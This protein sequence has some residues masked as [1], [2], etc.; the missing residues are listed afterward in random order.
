MVVGVS[1]IARDVTERK[2]IERQKDI[3]LGIAA[4]ELRTPVAGIK[5]YAQLAARRLQRDGE[6][7]AVEPLVQL[8][9]Q[10]DRLMR[11]I[12]DL[13]NV[14]RIESD[15]LLL[16][17]APVVLDDLITDVAAEFQR[18][19]D[20]H[21]IELV[22]DAPV[23]ITA[24]RDRIEQ[25]VMNLLTNAVKFSPDADVVRIRTSNDAETVVVSVEDF[26]VGIPKETQPHI[27]ER[28]YRIGGQNNLGSPGLG[29]GLFISSEYVKRHGGRIWV[30]SV[31]GSGTTVSFALPRN[32]PPLD[33]ETS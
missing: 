31:E 26:G 18:I 14:T 3:F 30:E 24:D 28:F 8:D 16:R 10:V 13:L 21:R 23:S 5:G 20:Q 15:T 6:S 11:L 29:L 25:V 7:S 22:L 9:G 12:D 17:A 4:H 27:F 1:K 2:E 32:P 33:P 19:S